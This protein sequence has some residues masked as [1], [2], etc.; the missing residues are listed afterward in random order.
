MTA[1]ERAAPRLR[2]AAVDYLNA[3]PLLEGLGDGDGLDVRTAR[4]AAVADALAARTCDVGLVPSFEAARLGLVTTSDACVAA[5][6]AVDSVLLFLRRA[7]AD[8]RRTALDVASR[9]SRELATWFLRRAGARFD[10]ESVAPGAARSDP[11]YDAVL[12]IGDDALRFAADGGPAVDLAAAWAAAYGEPFV[13]A[14]WAATPDALERRPDLPAL[15]SAARD[16]GLT[17]LDAYAAEA[18]GP[19]GDATALSVYL[20]R[21]LRYVLGPA[22]RRGLAR[23]LD[24]AL[25]AS[26]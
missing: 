15:L 25:P 7:P 21:R 18:A 1:S 24:A 11:R 8:V 9:T 10:A 20:R 17:R 26:R 19:C 4:P 5:Y 6:G 2:V 3:R 13:F 22:E 14:T 23:F 12:A 16:R